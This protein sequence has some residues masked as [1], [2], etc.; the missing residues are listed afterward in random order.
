[1][2]PPDRDREGD[3]KTQPGD[4]DGMNPMCMFR[5]QDCMYGPG[6][7]REGDGKTEPGDADGMNPMCMFRPQDCWPPP[8]RGPESDGN[9]RPSPNS[10]AINPMCML[11]P[12]DKQAGDQPAPP[13]IDTAI[14]ELQGLSRGLGV[15]PCG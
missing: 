14:P 7:D 3:G 15:G 12:Q 6:R 2:Y 11:R 4:A 8:D 13:A 5:P 10:G 1:M 9:G